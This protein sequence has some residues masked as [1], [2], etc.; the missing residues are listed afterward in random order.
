M[1]STKSLD[2]KLKPNVI[3]LTNAEALLTNNV[4]H[5]ITVCDGVV[6]VKG[7]RKFFAGEIVYIGN[8][9][10]L[11]LALA[12][13]KNETVSFA[14]FGGDNLVSAGDEVRSTSECIVVH[15]GVE[16][17]EQLVV[18]GLGKYIEGGANITIDKNRFIRTSAISPGIIERHDSLI[19]IGD[20][21]TALILDTILNQKFI[22]LQSYP[23]GVEEDYISIKRNS[24]PMMQTMSNHL[25]KEKGP[26]KLPILCDQYYLD[27]KYGNFSISQQFCDILLCKNFSS[28]KFLSYVTVVAPVK[29]YCIYNELFV[30]ERLNKIYQ[31][32]PGSWL[33]VI[34]IGILNDDPTL[35]YSKIIS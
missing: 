21:Q 9:G 26:S 2:N 35:F 23:P 20:R 8:F 5:V 16:V 29:L 34:E 3:I 7:F 12:L 22:N 1:K 4:G 11:G 31:T 24:A 27:L 13:E 30:D 14:T 33:T 6:N 19:S 17:L 18:D 25:I 32:K 15:T 28:I 10:A